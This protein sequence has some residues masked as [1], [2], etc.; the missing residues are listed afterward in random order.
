MQAHTLS[1]TNRDILTKHLS[2]FGLNILGCSSGKEALSL[3]MNSDSNPDLILIDHQMPDMDGVTLAGR[4]KALKGLENV[5]I[6]LLSSWGRINIEELRTKG[7]DESVI[8]PLR[9]SKL[10]ALLVK[11]LGGEGGNKKIV[12]EDVMV[13]KPRPTSETNDG[14]L[15]LVVDD[16]VDNRKLAKRMLE[17]AGYRVDLA[18][19]GEESITAACTKDYDAILMDIQMPVIDGFDATK[20]IRAWE[21]GK[22]SGRTPI[23]AVTAHALAGYREKCLEEDMDDYLTKPLKK[24]VL[25]DLIDKWITRSKSESEDREST[26]TNPVA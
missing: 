18:Q 1:Q 2:T 4:I 20:A 11:L 24:K 17:R 9:Q 7:I 25:L 10:P 3:L 6:A 15:I 14:P 21:K 8:K 19:G 5:K 26:G 23:I 12:P 22:N 13:E 16:M